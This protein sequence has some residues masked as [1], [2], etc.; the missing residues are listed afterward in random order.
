MLPGPPLHYLPFPVAF[1][2]LIGREEVAEALWKADA[3][4]PEKR[5]VLFNTR[6]ENL[7][8]ISYTHI[9]SPS[10][11]LFLQLL[12]LVAL[13]S[14]SEPDLEVPQFLIQLDLLLQV[15]KQLPSELVA[16][17]NSLF[18]RKERSG[19]ILWFS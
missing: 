13:G 1:T 19:G 15:L 4:P 2:L 16:S 12:P 7:L 9:K 14:K 8:D 17:F 6:L 5:V 11:D 10:H 18:H 3:L